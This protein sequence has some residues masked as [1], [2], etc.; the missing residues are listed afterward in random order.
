M[1]PAEEPEG[2]LGEDV[3]SLDEDPSQLLEEC[4]KAL[5]RGT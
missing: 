3:L 4:P 2:D 1:L 5:G